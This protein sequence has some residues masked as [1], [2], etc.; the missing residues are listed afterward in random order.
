MK[1]GSNPAVLS[2]AGRGLVN[3]HG[4]VILETFDT[5]FV[6]PTT[7]DGDSALKLL[8]GIEGRNPNKRIIHVIWD[9]AACHKGPDVRAFLARKTCRIR[10]IQLPPNCPHHNPIERLWAVLHQHVTHNCYYQSQMQFA[11]DIL[12]F[13]RETIPREWKNFRD[14]VSDNFRVITCENFRVLEWTRYSMDFL[15]RPLSESRESTEG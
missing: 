7:V 13:M 10:L 9:N 4:A 3:V 12:T 11:D 14:P 6:E 1:A 5:P 15:R 8:A 2:T